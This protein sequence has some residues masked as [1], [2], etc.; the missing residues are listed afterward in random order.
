MTV[1]PE[2]AQ[3]SSQNKNQKD[4]SGRLKTRM[5]QALEDAVEAEPVW[6]E[7]NEQDLFR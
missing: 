3:P 4:S 6:I 1:S 7:G 2:F 5:E